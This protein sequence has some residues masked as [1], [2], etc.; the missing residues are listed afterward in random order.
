[1][2]SRN[3]PFLVIAPMVSVNEVYQPLHRRDV[4]REVV[5]S[6]VLLAIP[7]CRAVPQALLYVRWNE[8]RGA[9]TQVLTEL[10]EEYVDTSQVEVAE[11]DVAV[12][13]GLQPGAQVG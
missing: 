9:L 6:M 4:G 2:K 1:M 13:D 7:F 5:T 8:E 10:G 3:V 11:V 12:G